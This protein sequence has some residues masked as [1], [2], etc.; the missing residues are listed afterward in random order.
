MPICL[1]ILAVVTLL[2]LRGL[3]DAARAFLLP[4][5][6]FIVGL[7]VIITIG[8]IYP[9]ALHA[10]QP[11]RSLLPAHALG[12]VSV[13]L[14]L[15]AFSAGC[16]ALTG[17]E[18]IANG[19]PLFRQ[20]RVAR[21]KQTELM[22]G[23]ILGAMLLGLAVLADR[24]QIGPRS[25]Q[26]VLS[27]IIAAA[28]GRHWA[29]Y[30]MSLTITLVLALA[31][32]TSFGSLPV[33]ASLLARDDYLPRRF[34][35]RDDRQVFAAGIWVLATMSAALLVAVAGNTLKLIPLF[36]IGVFTGFTL[37]QA[38][39]VVHWQRSRPPGWR[40]RA[41]INGIGA[42]ATAIATVVFL[43]TKFTQGAWVVVLAVPALI[44]LF[45]R[46][47][48]YYE[49]AGHVLGF[50][51]IPGPPQGKPVT[52]V[53]PVA[54]VSRLTQHAISEA[55]SISQRVIA[56]T[57]VAAD[58]D[59][60]AGHT[61]ALR[62]Q[63]ARWNPGVPLRELNT[64]YASIAGPFVA[65]IDRLRRHHD[66]QIIVLI[67]VVRPDRL[68]DRFLHNHLDVV[69]SRALRARTDIVVARVPMPLQLRDGK[70]GPSHPA[71]GAKPDY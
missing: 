17:V 7:L 67:P 11:G 56:V 65:F 43:A 58:P 71:A 37:A 31:A 54:G 13:L 2:N 6:L 22:L 25:G 41:A 38:G 32:N 48:R 51:T 1:G 34:A 8:L 19:V 44:V 9:L 50:G 28:I 15:K 63:W 52:V 57:V 12:T 62:G 36:A 10:P 64:Q 70:G 26:T 47:R 16:S 29:Y 39:M 68:R 45:T 60:S 53:V 23:G 59:H 14:L 30:V 5:M 33:L 35:L 24:W 55:L 27:Q 49:L 66:E 3:A 18:A 21:A 61:H 42:V 46:I 69:L 4:T 40:H 20:P